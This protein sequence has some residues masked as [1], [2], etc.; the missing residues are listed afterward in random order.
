VPVAATIGRVTSGPTG[1]VAVL[2]GKP[3]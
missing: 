3:I 1:A 2:A